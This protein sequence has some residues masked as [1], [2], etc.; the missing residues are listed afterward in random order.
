MSK[1]KST[2]E[3]FVCRGCGNRTSHIRLFTHSI[4]VSVGINPSD[5]EEVFTE[6][7]YLLFECRTCNGLSLKNFFPDEVDYSPGGLDFD[8]INYL[9]PSIKTFSDAD[10]VPTILKTVIEEA[11]KVKP[12]SSMA[13]LIL[14]RKALEEICRDKGF[15]DEHE[16]L[17]VKVTKLISKEN[18]PKVFADASH[19]LR[20]FGNKGAHDSSIK[21]GREDIKLI[22]EFI[23]ALI[24]YIYIIP[25][26][27]SKLNDALEKQNKTKA[28]AQE[29]VRK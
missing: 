16:K 10:E 6:L 1:V 24:E 27:L 23:F 26:K 12:V 17:S 28:S 25:N 8:Y 3:V 21:V 9:Y 20:I 18:L 5:G 7:L 4:N 29:V 14:V 13:Y 2:D 11:N 19:K 15:T 22:E